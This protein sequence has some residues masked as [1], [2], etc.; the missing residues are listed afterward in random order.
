MD[1]DEIRLA[2]LRLA[3]E[4]GGSEREILETAR[5]WCDFVEGQDGAN[6]FRA[7]HE[8]ASKVT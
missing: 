2:C 5:K 8:S 4:Q 6:T 1:L 3:K 7:A